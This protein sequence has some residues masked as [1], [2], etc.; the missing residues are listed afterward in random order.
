MFYSC[1][2]A[3]TGGNSLLHSFSSHYGNKKILSIGASSLLPDNNNFINLCCRPDPENF[4][5]GN[6]V[7]VSGHRNTTKILRFWQ[8]DI[9]ELNTFLVIRDPVSLFWSSFYQSTISAGKNFSPESF[10]KARR[11]NHV[12]HFISKAYYDLIGGDIDNARN[13]F[14]GCIKYIIDLRNL[15]D[16]LSRINPGLKTYLV[17]PCGVRN[18]TINFN[19][20]PLQDDKDFNQQVLMHFES[21]FVFYKDCLDQIDNKNGVSR[22]YQPRVLENSISELKNRLTAEEARSSFVNFFYKELLRKYRRMG[23]FTFTPAAISSRQVWDKA[24]APYGMKLDDFL[25]SQINTC[26]KGVK[27]LANCKNTGILMI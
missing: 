21:D 24:F 8:N 27:T 5:L 6:F 18:Q 23:P 20:N 16:D 10:L 19:K 2:L 13:T 7:F 17:K 12:Q 1:H 14:F 4:N 11:P 9:K 22:S 25:A 26:K 3:K 15:T